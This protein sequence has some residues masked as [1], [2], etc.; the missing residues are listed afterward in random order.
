MNAREVYDK[1]DAGLTRKY[2]AE[3]NSRGPLGQIAVALFRAQKRSSRAKDY[4]RGRYR[5]AAYDVKSWSMSEICRLLAEHG[6]T[7]G[8]RWGWKQDSDVRFGEEAAWVLYVD[9]PERFGQVSFHSPSR[10]SGPDYPGDWDGQHMSAE[11]IIRF[12]N[13]VYLGADYGVTP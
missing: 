2:Y 8:F 1:Q 7:L 9:L 12:C 3:L 13:I 10:G 5:S 4:R 11:H 6:D